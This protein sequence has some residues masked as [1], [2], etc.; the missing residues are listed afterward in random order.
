MKQEEK[1]K[2]TRSYLSFKIGHE[3]F[4]VQVGQVLEIV[5]VPGI[6][7]VPQSP[8]YMRGLMNLRGTVLPVVDSRIKLN[9]PPSP[10]TVNTC[11]IVMNLQIRQ[12][13]IKVGILVDAAVE[14]LEIA[15]DELIPPP[16]IGGKYRTE[17]IHGIA[18]AHDALIIFLD[19][20]KIFSYEDIVSLKAD[21]ENNN[22][23][24]K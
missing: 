8:P 17:F 9:L 11:I 2:L 21:G 15:Q 23:P 3:I 1:K 4:A 22:T 5:E 10:D 7:H 18:E 6:T 12:E 20:D 19:V 14:V 13:E 16:E 24:E